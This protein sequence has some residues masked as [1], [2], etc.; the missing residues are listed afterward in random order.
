MKLPLANWTGIQIQ[1]P[2]SLY[3]C[4]K[5]IAYRDPS[6]RTIAFAFAFERLVAGEFD[7]CWP[8]IETH[9]TKNESLYFRDADSLVGQRGGVFYPSVEG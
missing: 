1:L 2:M 9:A 8:S 4:I 3:L 5:Q 7:N 6:C